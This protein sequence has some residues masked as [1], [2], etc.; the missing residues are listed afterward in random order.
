[1]SEYLQRQSLD[2]Q[3]LQTPLE[4]QRIPV[5]AIVA[6][7]V[8]LARLTLFVDGQAIG[9]FATLPARLVPNHLL[10]SKDNLTTQV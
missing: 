8:K 9:E 1:M 3:L 10:F 4:T 5:Q 2:P 6:D 7:G